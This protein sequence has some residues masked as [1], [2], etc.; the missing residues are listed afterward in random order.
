MGPAA[1]CRDSAL[2]GVLG[3]LVHWHRS[4]CSVFTAGLCDRQAPPFAIGTHTLLCKRSLTGFSMDF[5]P[6]LGATI[7]LHV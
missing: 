6:A 5:G 4:L 7:V 3:H 2:S 1:E